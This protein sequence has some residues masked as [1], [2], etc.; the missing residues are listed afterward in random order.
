MTTL[1]K[2]PATG[3]STRCCALAISKNPGD[4]RH[5][6]FTIISPVGCGKS[7]LVEA[8]YNNLVSGQSGRKVTYVKSQQFV[9]TL[10]D[11]IR[12]NRE[13][14]FLDFCRNTDILILD[15]FH[16]FE[17]YD[18]LQKAITEMF[19]ELTLKNSQIVIAM[20]PLIA[21]SGFYQGLASRISSG[22]RV[23]IDK[24]DYE[25][26]LEFLKRKVHD[27][28][29][30]IS[31][32]VLEYLARNI[33]SDVR[34]LEGALGSLTKNSN[35]TKKEIDISLAETVLEQ[36]RKSSRNK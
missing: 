6:P 8:I 14:D 27:S 3:L 19:D 17:G 26:R 36:I 10:N 1:W 13:K 31:D 21:E 22:L 12:N 15:D 11:A 2:V 24:P 32:H 28:E 18:K 34:S 4:R 29:F 25:T 5:N 20:Y 9:K 30:N 33:D 23:Y 16:C 35:E 7:H